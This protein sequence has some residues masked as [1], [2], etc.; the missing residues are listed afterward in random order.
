V[1]VRS[2]S[3]S[4]A[5]FG[6]LTELVRNRTGLIVPESHRARL[7]NRLSADAR[8]AGS[9]YELYV[10]FREDATD[11]AE[12]GRLLDASVNGETYFFRDAAG[13]AAFAEEIV[14]ERCLAVGA[15]GVIDVWSAG[16]AT[17]EE[18]YTLAMVLAEKGPGLASGVRIRGSDASPAFVR[19]ARAGRYGAHSLRETSLERRERFFDLQPDGS[20]DVRDGIRSRVLFEA[21][22]FALERK[23]GPAYDVIVCRNVLIYLDREARDATIGLFSSRLK[24]GGYLLLGPSDVLAASLTPLTMVRLSNDVAYRK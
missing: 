14:P 1:R 12:F 10:R 17:G 5:V 21:R 23:D 2:V 16:C 19:K 13:L 15:E 7:E 6:L 18:V 3:L 11:A 9:F 22:P 4:D 20:F 24:P 8:A